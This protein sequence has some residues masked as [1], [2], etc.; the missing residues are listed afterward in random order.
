MLLFLLCLFLGTTPLPTST[1]GFSGISSNDANTYASHAI[2]NTVVIV[3]VNAGMLHWAENLLCSLSAT[4]FNTSQIVFW[5]LH[6]GAEST[7]RRKGH[8]TYR[9]PSL[10]GTNNNENYRGDTPAYHRMMKERPKFFINVLSAGFGILML[11]A[12][13]V[14]W[15]SPLLLMPQRDDETV[16][17]STSSSAPML[18]NSTRRMMRSR[19]L[20]I[21]GRV[22]NRFAIGSS[23]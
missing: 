2:N 18:G 5:A 8:A 6:E 10:F 12:D 7:L 4:S 16:A 23:G 13:T 17:A 9:D 14:F 22:Y 1:P 15:Q 19:M 3:P 20:D 11:D 21:E